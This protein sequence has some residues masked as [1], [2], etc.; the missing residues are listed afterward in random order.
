MST[1]QIESILKDWA[2]WPSLC[3][4]APS[5]EQ[6]SPLVDGLTNSNWLLTIDT[7]EELGNQTNSDVQQY[8]IRINATNN[9]AL[10]LNRQAEWDMHQNIADFNIC[11][12]FIYKDP[13]DIYWIRPFLKN[14]TL[15][16]A[17]NTN[18]NVLTPEFLKNIARQLKLIHSVP[19]SKSW[20]SINFPELIEHYWQQIKAKKNNSQCEFE[21]RFK[22]LRETLDV[23]LQGEE[24]TPCL[25]HMD[26]N[27]SNWILDNQKQHLI[28]WEYA[29]LGNKAWDIA[30]FCDTCNLT[31]QQIDIFL[32][33]YGAITNKQFKLASVQMQYLSL[34]WFYVQDHLS[35]AALH[36]ALVE[37][38]SR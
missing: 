21:A 31:P 32:K 4:S 27:P 13:K 38:P 18:T 3:S 36:K 7:N 33:S 37:L 9:L 35:D 16:S 30:V 14:H 34:L 24:Y 12:P 6:V 8:V 10:K 26:P 15:A 17:L 1:T 25:C 28:D 23:T 20:P 19:V 22:T 11:P 29:A 5:L 2:L